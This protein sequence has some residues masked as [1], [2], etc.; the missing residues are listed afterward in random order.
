LIAE[1]IGKL[2]EQRAKEENEAELQ[3]LALLNE[4]I[5]RD[6]E[7]KAQLR[8]EK[9]KI[10]S[11]KDMVLMQQMQNQQKG[12]Q[13]L[14]QEFRETNADKLI[15][16]NRELQDRLSRLELEDRS[17]HDKGYQT[18]PVYEGRLLA[19]IYSLKLWIWLGLNSQL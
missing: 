1:K 5:K 2:K 16:E 9:E 13:K 15:E 12:L 8:A 4:K 17:L 6:K 10:F 3:R 18:M 19:R 14:I 11:E 7:R